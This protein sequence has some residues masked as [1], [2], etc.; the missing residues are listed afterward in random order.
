MA[1]QMAQKGALQPSVMIIHT[2]AS[3]HKAG[4]DV[5]SLLIL[6]LYIVTSCMERLRPTGSAIV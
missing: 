4:P 5:G 2:W 1:H 6:M 3:W